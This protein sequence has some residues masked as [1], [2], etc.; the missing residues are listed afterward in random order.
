MTCELDFKAL[1][2]LEPGHTNRG[3]NPVKSPNRLC[4]S[5]QMLGIAGKSKKMLGC[6]YRQVYFVERGE[7]W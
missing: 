4:D 1:D 2:A 5:G 7:K 3:A 6:E